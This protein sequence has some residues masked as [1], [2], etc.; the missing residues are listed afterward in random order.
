MGTMAIICQSDGISEL[1]VIKGQHMA[2]C[3][4]C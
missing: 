1:L 3:D 2:D 4:F